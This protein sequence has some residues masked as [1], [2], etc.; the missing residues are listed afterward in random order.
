MKKINLVI[1]IMLINIGAFAQWNPIHSM[2][3]TEPLNDVM[4]LNADTGYVVGG[5]WSLPSSAY[6]YTT[7]GGM[8][9]N[10][11]VVSTYALQSV[12]FL[13]DTLG[14]IATSQASPMNLCYKTIDGGAS[15][16]SFNTA[17]YNDGKIYFKDHKIGFHYSPNNGDDV[18]YS[19]NG[20][21][22]W[23]H[24]ENGTF[25][26]NG[27][28]GMH[29]PTGSSIGYAVTA[30]GGEIYKTINDTVWTLSGQPTSQT[31]NA[32]YFVDDF[33]GYVLGTNV[34]LKT[35]DG[36]ANWSVAN[37]DQGGL[38]MYCADA[39]NC[40]VLTYNSIL[41]STDGC[42]T[43]NTMT[44]IT[45]GLHSFYFTD[46][47]AYAVGDGAYKLGATNSMA[48]TTFEDGISTFPNPSNHGDFMIDVPN[49][50]SHKL[51]INVYNL[52]GQLEFHQQLNRSETPIHVKTQLFNGFY[53]LEL[54]DG[55]N[56]VH[57]K[58]QIVRR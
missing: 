48:E 8:T 58:I 3:T 30:W 5:E 14:F 28:A 11:S 56:K 42:S 38:D 52:N 17:L 40:Y 21:V 31:Y 22:S 45:G 20:G 18:A 35:I 53:I 1:V 36:G 29:F 24:Y 10:T 26:G 32:V 6:F 43:F 13:N 23:A 50:F 4:F 25:G 41:K 54:T 15:W 47:T 51:E 57:S 12:Q 33:I 19:S 49:H 27:V 55:K 39:N 37:A 46:N 7:D 16:T 34:I 44:G 9:W 2:G